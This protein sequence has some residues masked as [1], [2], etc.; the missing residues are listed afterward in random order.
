MGN[1]FVGEVHS[2]DV[3][4]EEEE[5]HDHLGLVLCTTLSEKTG[6]KGGV[7]EGVEEGS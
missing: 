7:K 2:K 6:A 4:D 5:R 1:F 3:V